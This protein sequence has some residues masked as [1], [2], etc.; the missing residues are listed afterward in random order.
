MACPICVS[1]EG[2]AITA[3]LRAGA[4]VLVLA[5]TVIGV[6]IARFALRL[7]RLSA[8]LNAAPCEPNQS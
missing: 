2:T 3:G 6:L 8:A 5:A 7:W 1:P 4:I